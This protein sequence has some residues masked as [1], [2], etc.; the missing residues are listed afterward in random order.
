MRYLH[1]PPVHDCYTPYV[2]TEHVLPRHLLHHSFSRISAASSLL[3]VIVHRESM[4]E[5][6]SVC[7]CRHVLLNAACDFVGTPPHSRLRIVT[8]VIIHTAETTRQQTNIVLFAQK[9]SSC[10][11]LLRRFTCSRFWSSGGSCYIAIQRCARAAQCILFSA[12]YHLAHPFNTFLW[13][14]TST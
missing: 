13:C 6:E 11:L 4:R 5:R 3:L 9:K 1:H 14:L 12:S 8:L 2:Y 10:W 7:V